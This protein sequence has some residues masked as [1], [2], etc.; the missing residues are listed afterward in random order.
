[1]LGRLAL[2]VIVCA[3]IGCRES[4]T[5]TI[6]AVEVNACFGESALFDLDLPA[7][8]CRTQL[9]LGTPNTFKGCLIWQE[10]ASSR[11]LP[12]VW[13]G[14]WRPLEE[15]DLR[16]AGDAESASF[17]V[18]QSA[19]NCLS[20]T[21]MSN[22][23]PDEGCIA[24]VVGARFRSDAPGTLSFV[25]EQ[26]R[27]ELDG[28]L[29]SIY[30][31]C[32][33]CVSN[34]SDFIIDGAFCE[35]E[36]GS[37]EPCDTDCG[38]GTR[39]CSETGWSE[40]IPPNGDCDPPIEGQPCESSQAKRCETSCGVGQADCQ[41]SVW[42]ECIITE[43]NEESCGNR[44]DDDC[45]DV[46]DEGCTDECQL[47]PTLSLPELGRTSESVP[48]H[49]GAGRGYMW[50]AWSPTSSTN[51]PIS[52]VKLFPDLPTTALSEPSIRIEGKEIVAAAAV[53]RNE[54]A[55]LVQTDS[56]NLG[57]QHVQ[58]SILSQLVY[59]VADLEAPTHARLMVDNNR[60]TA[61]FVDNGLKARQFIFG[62]GIEIGA[63]VTLAETSPYDEFDVAQNHSSMM[64]AYSE[65]Y[66]DGN[67]SGL[68][69]KR[70]LVNLDDPTNIDTAF[71][72][73]EDAGVIRISSAPVITSVAGHFLVV[74]V[75]HIAD[76]G[77]QLFSVQLNSEGAL[78]NGPTLLH[79][80]EPSMRIQAPHLNVDSRQ[81]IGLTWLE[82]SLATSTVG[83]DVFIMMLNGSGKT[84]SPVVKL[85]TDVEPSE[86]KI[87]FVEPD[88][89]VLSRVV[90]YPEGQ[91]PAPYALQAEIFDTSSLCGE[92]AE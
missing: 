66:T 70:T 16:F 62:D 38:P 32:V 67:G 83:N 47:S 27:C 76:A 15:S 58:G 82:K 84:A 90:F 81:S 85:A 63:T 1:M 65:L 45:D 23:V 10:G 30:N 17:F 31:T 56:G 43:P 54:L 9:E 55:L 35:C 89:M 12:V 6:L 37:T 57:L 22:C 74:Y 53:N 72:T 24:R 3:W 92:R 29:L 34:S 73:V 91:A 7:T 49:R 88:S 5:E 20:L 13:Q 69:L 25:D 2:F 52:F 42:G 33:T 75:R 46:I 86:P 40:C 51:E 36:L 39:Q 41:N 87:D 18:G 19:M 44:V 79:Q 26:G 60:R 77:S 71:V 21:S 48:I 64:I 8:T 4:P 61:I 11:R 78:I 50:F 14:G 59:E 28:S 68:T 80:S